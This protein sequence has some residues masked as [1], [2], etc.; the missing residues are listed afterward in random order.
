MMPKLKSEGF[1]VNG[2]TEQTWFTS[3]KFILQ[4]I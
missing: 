3:K 2:S 4:K 1:S